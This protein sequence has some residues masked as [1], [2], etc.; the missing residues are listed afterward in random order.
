M[1]A[2]SFDGEA[3]GLEAAADVGG[4]GSGG[5]DAGEGVGV[6]EGIVGHHGAEEVH[7]DSGAVRVLLLGERVDEAVP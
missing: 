5:E 2:G 4:F 3:V 1:K 7:D 6:G